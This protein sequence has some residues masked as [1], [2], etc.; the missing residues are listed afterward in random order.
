MIKNIS[1]TRCNF[2]Y[3]N[4]KVDRDAGQIGFCKAE[5]D[6][7]I[8]S[9][10]LHHGEEPPISGCYG[11]GAIFF[12]HCCMQCVYC[13]NYQFSQLSDKDERS[14]DDLAQ[15]M[16]KLQ[17]M[18]AHNINFV[19]PTHYSLQILQSIDIAK[20]KGLNIPLVF[21]T[22]GYDSQETIKA[23]KDVAD[24]YIVDMKYSNDEYAIKFSSSPGYININRKIVQE[25][26]AQVGALE[27]DSNGIA[28]K[29]LI[30]RCLVLPN[31][32][33]GT[34]ETLEWI[35]N[36]IS[37][38]VHI[39][40]M[41]QYYPVYSASKYEQINRKITVDEYEIV[42][43]KLYELGLSNGWIQDQPQTM[44]DSFAGHKIKKGNTLF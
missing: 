12:A 21:N 34:I 26:Y 24:V 41:S 10:G 1:L 13:Q 39:S 32:I 33:S 4:C 22:G 36:N 7:A 3:R 6:P 19:S 31:N 40:L 5:K 44:G 11:S 23:F 38:K 27:M 9:F 14:I 37:Q 16:V 35:K 25:M 18:Q 2:C 29:G 17:A 8:Y 28:K 30:I 15:I 43:D 42:K 20:K